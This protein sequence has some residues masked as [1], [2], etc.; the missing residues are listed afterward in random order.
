[1]CVQNFFKFGINIQVDSRKNWLEFGGQSWR[2]LCSLP[3]KRILWK[4]P[5]DN[6]F[7]F[8]RNVQ[9]TRLDL[10]GQRSL[11]LHKTWYLAFKG[12]L[13]MFTC[14]TFAVIK[15]QCV[16]NKR[17]GW[18]RQTSTGINSSLTL[19]LEFLRLVFRTPS[20]HGNPTLRQQ[21]SFHSITLTSFLCGLL[22]LCNNITLL[23]PLLPNRRESLFWCCGCF[24]WDDAVPWQLRAGGVK[25]SWGSERLFYSS[26]LLIFCC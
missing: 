4:I 22:S 24:S 10:G 23:P 14:L 1:M 19:H 7:K 25:T 2:S 18:R 12:F 13:K 3:C 11:V 20:S 16:D 26:L 5:C 9:L 15:G 8:S 17:T 21:K 6:P